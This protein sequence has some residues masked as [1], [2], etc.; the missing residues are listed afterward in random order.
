MVHYRPMNYHNTTQTQGAT[1]ARY[2]HQAETQESV[3]LELFAGQPYAAFA[4]TEVQQ[5][6]SLNGAP[7]TSIRRALS[8]L[9]RA[10]ELEKTDRQKRGPYNRPEYLWRA[11]EKYR[12]RQRELFG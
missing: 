6:V 3:I 5:A 2:Q 10:G 7:L 11:A 9:T 12:T 8:N 4:P 1:L